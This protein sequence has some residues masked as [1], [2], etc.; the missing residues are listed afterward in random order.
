MTEEEY[1]DIHYGSGYL[2]EDWDDECDDSTDC[3]VDMNF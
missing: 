2:D 1:E 3:T